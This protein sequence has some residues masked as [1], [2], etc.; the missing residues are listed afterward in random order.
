MIEDQ[1][2]D[3]TSEDATERRSQSEKDNKSESE[4]ESQIPPE[5]DENPDLEDPRL[6]SP[7]VDPAQQ[8]QRIQAD[9]P[10]ES[11]KDSKDDQTS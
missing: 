8:D 10:E 11:D 5:V 3:V 6:Y 1:D 7:L 4:E 9:E 2:K